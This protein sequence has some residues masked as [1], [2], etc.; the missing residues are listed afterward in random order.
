MHLSEIFSTIAYKRLVQVDLPTG[1][2]QHEINGVTALKNFFDVSTDTDK[3]SDAIF[4]YYFNDDKDTVEEVSSFTFYDAR[5]KSAIHTHRSEWRL[6]Y[7][8]SILKLAR[9][10]DVLILAKHNDKIFG[11]IF[12]QNSHILYAALK[13]FN[14]TPANSTPERFN[15]LTS[16]Q[17]NSENLEIQKQLILEQ[18]NIGIEYPTPTDPSDEE[19]I[20]QKFGNN[21]PTTKEMSEFARTQV[22]IS[23]LTPDEILLVWIDREDQLFRALEKTIV[24]KKVEAGFADVEEFIKYSLSV[25]NRRKS[26]MGHAFENHLNELFLINQLQFERQ[27]KTEDKNTADFLFPSH[28]AY[29]DTNYPDNKLLMLA[30]KSTCKDRWRQVLTEANR[31]PTKYLCTLDTHL[32][33][34]QINEMLKHNLKL[35]IPEKMIDELY[36]PHRNDMLTLSDFIKLAQ[37][38]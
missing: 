15:I 19:I 36:S 38:L 18:L 21:F 24:V 27:V 28:Q 5:A 29:H 2:N 33:D 25:H 16:D 13:L 32:S 8:G 6:Y 14:I 31:I 23:G 3:I 10:G 22:D 12:S 17:L 26:R 35:V 30:A 1:S 4:W 37:N 9:V 7:S 11:L 20:Y 34:S